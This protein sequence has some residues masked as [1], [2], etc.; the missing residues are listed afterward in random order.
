MR[1]HGAL[2]GEGAACLF[3]KDRQPGGLPSVL[4]GFKYKLG[5][6]LTCL[7]PQRARKAPRRKN[8]STYLLSTYCVPGTLYTHT[9][10]RMYCPQHPVTG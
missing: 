9:D 4:T 5:S 2:S 6:L 7:E 3:A 10:P 8:K 1:V